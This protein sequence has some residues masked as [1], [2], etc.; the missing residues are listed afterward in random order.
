MVR[1]RMANTAAL[2]LVVAVLVAP[3]SGQV[4][5]SCT[6]SLITTF[7]P[8]LNFVT[9]STN[10]GGSP[11]QQ[12]CGSLAEMVRSGA[13]CVCLILTG[14]VPFSLPINRTLAISFS[15]LCNSM[16]VPLQCRDTASQIPPPGP[17]VFA[18]ALPPLPP[19]PPEPSVQPNSEVDPTAMSPSPPIIQGQRPLLLPSLAWRRAHVSMAS[20]SVV[21]LIAATV[22]A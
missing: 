15:R 13:D 9:G 20:V 7:T 8:C 3:A 22:L 14:N 10:G 18:P 1:G 12:C 19:S 11:T 16:S 17:V 5:T 6:A 21:L 2:L 4:A